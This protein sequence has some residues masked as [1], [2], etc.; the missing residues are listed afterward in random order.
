MD[1]RPGGRQG[2]KPNQEQRAFWQIMAIPL[3]VVILIVVI[4]IADRPDKV[5]KEQAKSPVPTVAALETG[6]TAAVII[7]EEQERLPEEPGDEPDEESSTEAENETKPEESDPFATERFQRDSVPE[8]LDLMR[9][10]FQSRISADAEGMNRLYGIEGLSSQ[11]LDAQTVRMRSNSKYIQDFENIATYVMESTEP[12]SWLVY[13][14]TDINFY[15]S[16]TRAPMVMWCYV[17]KGEDGVYR[18]VNNR[19]VSP[20]ALQFIQ[21]ANYSA[22][23]R[24]LAADVNRRLR[25]ALTSDENLNQVYGVLRD[26]SPVWDGTKETEP[27]VSIMGETAG[28]GQESGS[29]SVLE[30][31]LEE[32]EEVTTGEPGGEAGGSGGEAAGS[33]GETE[34]GMGNGPTE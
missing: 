31:S 13:A 16:K 21:E 1:K 18:I 29:D 27:E 3:I 30:S 26:G 22:E 33:G 14:V 2:L 24:N 9:N 11:E 28:T 8:I 10:Y 15:T 12:D 7:E 19:N 4:R 32:T 5:K 23:V 20:Q 25:E 17:K 6:V 34:A